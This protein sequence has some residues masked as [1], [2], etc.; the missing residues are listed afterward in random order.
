MLDDREKEAAK[1]MTNK[2]Q[3]INW[4]SLTV[5]DQSIDHWE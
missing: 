2:L 4:D 1:D 5:N 3:K